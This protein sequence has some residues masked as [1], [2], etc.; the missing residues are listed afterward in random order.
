M[1][2]GPQESQP[3]ENLVKLVRNIVALASTLCGQEAR[4]GLELTLDL[5]TYPGYDRTTSKCKFLM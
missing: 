2:D 1:T 4:R 5:P 3:V